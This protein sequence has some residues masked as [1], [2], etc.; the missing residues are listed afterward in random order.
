MYTKKQVRTFIER[1]LSGI[2]INH[3]DIQEYNAQWNI[4]NGSV[5]SD[6]DQIFETFKYEDGNVFFPKGDSRSLIKEELLNK[7]YLYFGYLHV[8]NPFTSTAAS[9]SYRKYVSYE[10]RNWFSWRF[11]R[12]QPHIVNNYAT[13]IYGRDGGV[14]ASHPILFSSVNVDGSIETIQG[15]GGT[16]V[17][18]QQI[19]T[20]DGHCSDSKTAGNIVAH[21]ITQYNANTATNTPSVVAFNSSSNLSYPNNSYYITSPCGNVSYSSKSDFEAALTSQGFVW[22]PCYQFDVTNCPAG[23]FVFY[24][25]TRN[26]YNLFR[27]I[28]NGN[29]DHIN[30]ITVNDQ[31]G[32]AATFT[33]NP[34]PATA[35]QNMYNFYQ[36]LV[37]NPFFSPF[38]Y[39]LIH[40]SQGSY[41]LYYQD[42]NSLN[43]S[44]FIELSIDFD[45]PNG[46][47]RVYQGGDDGG[48][49]VYWQEFDTFT[50]PVI[51]EY[52]EINKSP[53]TYKFIFNQDILVQFTGYRIRVH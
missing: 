9:Q 51:E 39:G 34:F 42:Q 8:T 4:L 47:V 15:S 24:Y 49:Q 27:T 53:D 16:P 45:N 10:V 28:V 23:N 26:E 35:N 48:G 32:N 18:K 37:S 21:Q 6:D 33:F 17:R 41:S 38:V 2:G 40:D 1:Q 25:N 7:D 30:S 52:E 19:L 3:L 36:W 31:L 12:R 20:F 43:L 5:D 50:E 11:R 14:D 29:S 44:N 46:N 13:R 22:Q